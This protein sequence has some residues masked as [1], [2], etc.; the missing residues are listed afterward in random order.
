VKPLIAGHVDRRLGVV[1]TI[2]RSMSRVEL[3]EHEL[4]EHARQ[5]IRL[6]LRACDSFDAGQLDEHLSIATRLRVLLQHNPSGHSHALLHRLGLHDEPIWVASGGDV[7]AENVLPEHKL[8]LGGSLSGTQTAWDPRF[9]EFGVKPPLPWQLQVNRMSRGIPKPRGGDRG[10]TFE[11]WWNQSVI[12]DAQRRE[13]SRR[14]LVRVVSNQDGGAHV[15]PRVDEM[16]YQL[17]RLNSLGISR[18]DRPRD[19]PVPATLRQIGWEVHSMLYEHRPDL[20]PPEAPP[21]RGS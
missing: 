10:R 21:P 3:S 7:V 18:G 14:D 4:I 5:Q 8:L 17:T 20:L 11:D 19:S 12:R 2:L 16:H 9:A 6:L 15:D 13:F 1:R